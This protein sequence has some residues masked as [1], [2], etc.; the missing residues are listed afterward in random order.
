MNSSEVFLL[1]FLIGVVAGLRCLTAPAVVAWA[2]H[3]NWLN[4]RGSG[5]AFMGSLAAVIVFTLL[6]IGELAGDKRP[7]APARTAPLGLISR[8]V[9]GSLSG[10]CIGVAG[11]QSV[12]L[13]AILGAVGA[14][15]GAFG[16]YQ[17][18]KRV[19]A[20]LTVPDFAIALLE[21]AVTIASGLLIVS[22][23]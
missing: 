23:F 15:A 12:V 4:L 10:A 7:S 22:R 5:V 20:A 14:V 13:C 21:D 16:G 9:T 17:L 3:L 6:A 18:R 11:S 2:A 8:I 19:V 1:A